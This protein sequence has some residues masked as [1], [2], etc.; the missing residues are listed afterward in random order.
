MSLSDGYTKQ[1]IVTLYQ[2]GFKPPQTAKI[3]SVE[4]LPG[5]REGVHKFLRKFE[6]TGCLNRHLGSGHPSKLTVEIQRLVE[7][8]MRQDDKTTAYQLHS[9]LLSKGYYLSL[10]SVL[11]CRTSMGW[12]F[13]GSAYCQL[14]R[15]VNK[16]KI[17]DWAKIYTDDD[18]ENVMSILV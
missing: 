10:R 6:E 8:Q 7:E 12:T 14:I 4:A 3:L 11:R 16:K 15:D 13:R 17:F 9:L 5:S 1:R 2:N 18:F